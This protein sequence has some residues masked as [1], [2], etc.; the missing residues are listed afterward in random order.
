[1]QLGFPV[2]VLPTAPA[3]KA[4]RYI[5]GG[6]SIPNGWRCAICLEAVHV[7]LA[8]SPRDASL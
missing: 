4:D 5:S 6:R 2:L 1:V 8:L 3:P 7:A